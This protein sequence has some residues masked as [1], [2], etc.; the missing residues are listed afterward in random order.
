[1]HRNIFFIIISQINSKGK[2]DHKTVQ[3][4]FS[5]DSSMFLCF[6]FFFFSSL[7]FRSISKL[8]FFANHNQ[9]AK[10]TN[11][12]SLQFNCRK[13]WKGGFFSVEGRWL[14]RISTMVSSFNFRYFIIPCS[15]FSFG[16]VLFLPPS[17]CGISGT[18]KVGRV[19]ALT[20]QKVL[21]INGRQPL[22]VC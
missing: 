19:S 18:G 1:M 2:T 3:N 16:R 17:W 20:F 7:I 9:R 8:D 11:C 5:D 4:Y 6:C 10:I 21:L 13:R 22:L 14:I 15:S 12:T